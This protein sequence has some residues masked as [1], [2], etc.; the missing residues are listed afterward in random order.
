[1]RIGEDTMKKQILLALLVLLGISFLSAY[2]A[3][4]IGLFTP[5]SLDNIQGEINLG[6]RFYGKVNHD[7]LGTFFGT[8]MGANATLGYRQHILFG[9]EAKL[10][11]TS[12]NKMYE[13]GAAWRYAT[14]ESP[15][16][17]QIDLTA[18]FFDKE[19]SSDRASDFGV[20]LSAQNK[21]VWNRLIFTLNAGYN[22]YYQ[23]LA[24][25]VGTQIMIT[26]DL[27]LLGEFYPLLNSEDSLD[28]IFAVGDH[29]AFAAGI[30]F[31]TYGHSFVFSLGNDPYH[32]N[33]AGHG[34][35]TEYKDTLHLGFNIR[36]RL[37]F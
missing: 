11:Y 16:K 22:T 14:D 10:A 15:V 3:N 35:G 32:F 34:L 36:R 13:L 21:P 37:G 5:S 33:T 19:L 4:S 29:S 20:M 31:D 27:S 24:L 8:S 9:T 2:Q 12:A 6:H 30:A 26:D 17:A 25:G 7:V 1:M 23:R 28:P 18:A